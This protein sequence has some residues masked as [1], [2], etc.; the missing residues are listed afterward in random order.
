[1]IKS[2]TLKGTSGP[3]AGKEIKVES[4]QSVRVG[5]TPKAGLAT[6]DSYMSGEHFALD[7]SAETCRIRDLNSRNGTLLNGERISDAVLHEGDEIFAGQTTLIV[8]IEEGAAEVELS[9]TIK[10]NH[11]PALE[12]P[13]PS[14]SAQPEIPAASPHPTT[15]KI[16]DP[17]T[18]DWPP[19]KNPPSPV[20]AAPPPPAVQEKIQAPPPA[21]P[22][23]PKAQKTPSP[24][25]K[26]AALSALELASA[27]T[28]EG[29]LLNILREDR[30]S[31]FALLD[32]AR[33]PRVPELLR[34]SGEEYQSL[35]AGE[36]FA[37]SAPYLV[38][39]PPS[40]RLLDK[41]VHEGWGKGWIV[42]L[43]CGLP[44]QAVRDYFRQSLMIKMPDG[45]E[46]FS[47]FYDP[48]FFRGFLR[49][50]AQAEA[51][52][53]FGPINSYLMEAENA[54]ILLQFTKSG[55][56]VETKERLLLIPGT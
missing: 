47:R 56:G 36:A 22:P 17:P 34:G 6:L 41:L 29:R 11:K 30:E 19:A 5:R 37:E 48:R 51:E 53:F 38:Y 27:A 40:S 49:G 50:C 23:I 46:F 54:E 4:G 18:L 16:P 28:P 15:E 24:L 45:Q 39:L 32:A 21:P 25:P 10:I 44:L 20:V 33:E 1:M 12:S 52:R 42:Y 3:F 26:S 55:T 14:Q 8:H 31:L 2:L 9:A 13:Q 43:T 35:Y 7:C